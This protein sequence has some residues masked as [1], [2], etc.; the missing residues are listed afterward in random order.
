M[1]APNIP[2]LLVCRAGRTGTA[3]WQLNSRYIRYCLLALALS[4]AGHTLYLIFGPAPEAK[5]YQLRKQ[6]RFEW[7]PVPDVIEIPARPKEVKRPPLPQELKT[8]DE[9]LPEEENIPGTEINLD[10]PWTAPERVEKI[11]EFYAFETPPEAIHIERPEYPELARHAHA[12]GKVHVQVTID[13]TGRVI[14]AVVLKSNTIASLEKAAIK[15]AYGCLFKPALQ[16]DVR[17]KA[18]IVLKFNFTLD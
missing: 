18:R 10:R 15:A 4:L 13:E 14:E 12:E 8:S 3:Y 17:V 6:P 1:S 7:T 5:P 2:P 11:E 9:N 16:R